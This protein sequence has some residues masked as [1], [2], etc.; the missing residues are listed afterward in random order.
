MN[1]AAPPAPGSSPAIALLHELRNAGVTLTPAIDYDGPPDVLTPVMLN[2]I[3]GHKPAM[4]R[5]LINPYRVTCTVNPQ[6]QRVCDLIADAYDRD[7]LEAMHL[8]RTWY[9]AMD[10]A[11]RTR[12][13][14]PDAAAWAALVAAGATATTRET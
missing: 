13:H 1:A 12:H 7:V 3:R 8:A 6:R 14:D 10:H 5:L 2:R 11:R 9:A 4:L